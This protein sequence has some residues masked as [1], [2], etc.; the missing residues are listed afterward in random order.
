MLMS[1][2]DIVSIKLHEIAI[3][4]SDCIYP[5]PTRETIAKRVIEYLQE[6]K[7]SYSEK[8]TP[9]L[10][11][12]TSE[13]L[14]NDLEPITSK[15]ETFGDIESI[16]NERYENEDEYARSHE[17]PNT[18]AVEQSPESVESKELFKTFANED[19]DASD[20]RFKNERDLYEELNEA[21]TIYNEDNDPFNE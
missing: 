10:G 4:F 15:L 12:S 13:E 14:M 3:D 9:Q 5:E 18:I 1:R 8:R 2:P 16:L 17:G 11:L 20:Y 6:N 21:K 7:F 19:Y